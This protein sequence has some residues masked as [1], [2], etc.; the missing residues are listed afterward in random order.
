MERLKP[1]GGFDGR[2]KRY[3]GS[4]RIKTAEYTANTLNPR[5]DAVTVYPL[6]ASEG[7]NVVLVNQNS[8]QDGLSAYNLCKKFNAR[9]LLI[10]PDYANVGLM[11]DFYKAKNI[12][13]LGSTKEIYASTE[14]YIKKNMPGTRVIR[15]DAASPYDRNRQTI[16]MGGFTNLAV[17]DGRNFPDALASSGI[18]NNKNLG[19]LLV[20]GSKR[21][22]PL[23]GT[24]VQYTIG[25]AN[26]VVQER[27]IRLAGRDR[28]ETSKA[29]ARETFGYDNILFVDG[30]KFPDSISAINLVQPRNSIVML[31]SDQRNNS[32]MKEFL[33]ILPPNSNVP[34]LWDVEK[35]G[36][37]LIIGGPGSVADR[38][39][40][41]MLYPSKL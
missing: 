38:T 25:G 36:Y 14:S 27:G 10:K 7:A 40:Q 23:A 39:I 11:K 1:Y 4:N 15:V 26:S 24:T 9:L 22:T 19:L 5:K 16:K 41:K 31:I 12:Y 18:C 6:K 21:Y 17:A 30:R 33:S 2:W 34:N 8:F 3:Y 29:V 20:D 37:A 32:D 28:Y 13:L 35:S